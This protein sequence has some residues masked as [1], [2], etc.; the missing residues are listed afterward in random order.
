[1]PAN[2]TWDLIRALKGYYNIFF[3]KYDFHSK[4][5]DCD[6]SIVRR[7]SRVHSTAQ[8]NF[9]LSCVVF[10]FWAVYMDKA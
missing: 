6:L 7:V 4:S 9:V 10:I 2:S 8:Y 1:M 3:F 5:S